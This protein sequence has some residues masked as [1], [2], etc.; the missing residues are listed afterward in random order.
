MGM[1]RT[2]G[3]D[4]KKGQSAICPRSRRQGAGEE[5]NWRMETT[6]EKGVGQGR[7]AA[8]ECALQAEGDSILGGPREGELGG[9]GGACVP[10]GARSRAAGGT[11]GMWGLIQ[12][13][14][15]RGP[16]ETGARKRQGAMVITLRWRRG[17]GRNSGLAPLTLPS[18]QMTFKGL[19]VL[20]Q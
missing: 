17:R 3:R 7:V 1:L 6:L 12:S 16:S 15:V 19:M 8:W 13:G 4:V 18:W 14:K 9:T 5:S 11:K 10:D 2:L 20:S